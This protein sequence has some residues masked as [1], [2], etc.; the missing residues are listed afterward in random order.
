MKKNILQLLILFFFIFTSSA[1][2]TPNLT[3]NIPQGQGVSNEEFYIGRCVKATVTVDTGSTNSGGADLILNYNNSIIQIVQS[4]CSTA[5]TSIYAGTAYQNTP[6]NLVTSTQIKIGVYNGP[7]VYYNGVGGTLASFYFKVLT[8]GVD[9]ITFEFTPG[10]TGDSNISNSVGKDILDH[11]NNASLDLQTDDDTPTFSNFSPLPDQ[12]NVLIN[13]NLL[14]R[15]ND[16]KAGINSSTIIATVKNQT[17]GATVARSLASS[18][19]TTNFNRVDYCSVTLDPTLLLSYNTTYSIGISATDLGSPTTHIGTTSYT[20]STESDVTPPTLAIVSPIE[21]ATNVPL[22]TGITL[23]IT[24]ISPNGYGGTG[25]DLTN[26]TI[27]VGYLG[28]TSTTYN[29]SGG[30]TYTATAI[31]NGYKINIVPVDVFPENT[32][33]N[34]D[35]HSHDLVG[36]ILDYSYHFHTIDQSSPTCDQFIPTQNSADINTNDTISFHCSDNGVGI[37]ISSFEIVVDKI[38]YTYS[39][40]TTFSYSGSSSD[41]EISIQPSY[42]FP[43]QYGFEVIVNGKD[44]NNNYLTQISYGLATTGGACPTVAPTNTP[45]P[46]NTPAICPSTAPTSIPTT[47]YTNPTSTCSPCNCP[48]VCTTTPTCPNTP[49]PACPTSTTSYID[50]EIIKEVTL[51]VYSNLDSITITKINHNILPQ[52]NLTTIVKESSLL[53]EGKSEPNKLVNLVIGSNSTIITIKADKDGNW[54]TTLSNF[55]TNRIN[56][57]YAINQDFLNNLSTDKKFLAEIDNQ[58]QAN[59]RQY[60]TL[61]KNLLLFILLIGIGIGFI[62]N[63][64]ITDDLEDLKKFFLSSKKYDHTK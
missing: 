32:Q 37:D 21:N 33:I 1:L 6:L 56:S 42:F 3:L 36:N 24:D 34:V 9:P 7:G 61:D 60:I 26:T 55:L 51:N 14:F 28:A 23:N 35:V 29:Y 58:Y 52:N 64:L 17:T 19:H 22:S 5:A 16:L 2:A 20:F 46:T 15:A 40:A 50:K 12:T 53:I 11:V 10:S 27:T 49:C 41:Y 31:T 43:S 45:I 25:V 62:I 59:N 39:G 44:F 47:S 63:A 18:C 13:S 4:N 54:Q 30:N 48:S 57:I 38:K 8:N